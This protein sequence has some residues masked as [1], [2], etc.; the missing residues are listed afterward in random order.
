MQTFNDVGRPSALP[1]ARRKPCE[2]E[3]PIA[4]FFKA[5]GNGAVPQAP[6]AQK[7]LAS[8]LHFLE[9]ICVDHVSVVCRDL[10]MEPPGRVRE[11]ISVLVHCA[12]LRR[13]VAPA[14][15]RGA[16]SA[17]RHVNAFRRV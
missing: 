14:S 6:F 17:S 5:V 1:L 10:I 12:A 7:R 4:C 9:R 8:L 13:H 15:M 11:Q 16:V 3:E 2:G